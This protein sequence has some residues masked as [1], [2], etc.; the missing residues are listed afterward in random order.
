MHWVAAGPFTVQTSRVLHYAV[1]FAA[2]VALGASPLGSGLL[3]PEGALARRWGVWSV[4][5]LV[6]FVAGFAVVSVAIVQPS[7]SILWG[8]IGGLAFALSCAATSFGLLAAF[9][10]FARRR[11]PVLDSLRL[12]AYGI[13]LVHY[14]A[15]AWLQ[16][17]LLNAP[18]SGLVKGVVVFACATAVSWAV[19]AAL[20]RVP[21]IGWVI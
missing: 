14:G 17:S 4:A 9:L 16:Y 10:R 18:M 21:T 1:Y 2:G 8:T 20:R 11:T 13:Y 7:P 19:T 12:N 3:A 15:V 6:T 5:A